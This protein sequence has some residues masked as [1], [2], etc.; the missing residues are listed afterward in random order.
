MGIGISRC[1]LVATLSGVLVSTALVGVSA[2]TAASAGTTAAQSASSDSARGDAQRKWKSPVLCMNKKT[3][4]IKVRKKNC[5]KSE[6]RY[7]GATGATGATGAAAGSGFTYKLG[8]TGPGGGFIFFVDYND[9]FPAFKYL[10]AAPAP[11][12]TSVAWCAGGKGADTSVADLD[13]WP[14]NAVGRGQTNTNAMMVPGVCG[15]GAAN[16]ADAYSV[17]GA[18]DWFL[19]SLGEMMLMLTNLR[20]AGVGGFVNNDYWSSGEGSPT[21]AWNQN[22][23]GGGQDAV[24]K[25]LILPVRPARAFS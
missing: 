11:D 15:S 7:R 19:P 8:D 3:K 4:N 6:R 20:Q 10:E 18:T 16:S 25:N 5:R 12:L 1:A 14:A 21:V 9:Q 17:G 22:F 24:S 23:D 2:T 13:T